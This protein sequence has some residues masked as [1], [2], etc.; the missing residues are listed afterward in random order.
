MRLSDLVTGTGIRVATGDSGVEI[1]GV[2]EDSRACRPGFLFAALPGTVSHGRQ[3]VHNAVEN[4][5][6]AVLCSDASLVMPGITVAVAFP[7]RQAFS[8]VCANWYGHQPAT[9]VAVTGT[10]GKSSVADYCRQFWNLMG[11]KAASLGTLGVATLDTPVA[12]E[13]TTPDPVSLHRTLS[14]LTRNGIDRVV[15][16]ASSHGLDQ[17]R[18]DGVGLKAAAFTNISHDHLDY[19]ESESAYFGAKARLFQL[20]PETGTAVLN[21]D[22]PVFEKLQACCRARGLEIVTY[23]LHGN[24]LK[25]V[26]AAQSIDGS[27]RITAATSATTHFVDLAMPGEFQAMNVLCAAA[28]VAAVEDCSLDSCLA[29]AHRLTGVRGRLEKV[30]GH[31]GGARIYVDYA[32]TPDALHH[33]LNAVR[34]GVKG[35]LVL[36]FGCGGDRDQPKRPVM[37]RIAARFAD[38][39][40]VTDDNPRT[41]NAA[42]IRSA[43]M[44]QAPC[45]IEMDNRRQA[46]C[47]AVF[48][49]APDDVL[50]IAGKGHETGQIIGDSVL[51]F[52]DREEARK[53][54]AALGGTP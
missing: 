16:E 2:T 43:V 49:L 42:T 22:T 34:P 24:D 36:V 11:G 21:A 38:R 20:L 18:L 9:V 13:H 27:Q 19:H 50:V 30:G 47:E 14:D 44:A 32:H 6:V 53:A 23:G 1:R 52:D 40:Y 31:P 12:L 4:G 28:L 7:P 37:G 33:V 45:A 17:F 5:A 39:V 3:F 8:K 25:L 35:R 10:N 29:M 51:P 46:I 15:L 26:D 48:D 41:E 54:I